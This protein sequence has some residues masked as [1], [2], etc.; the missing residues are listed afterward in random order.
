MKTLLVLQSQQSIA[1]CTDASVVTVRA[2]GVFVL[3]VVFLHSVPGGTRAC[4][5]GS[6]QAL[7]SLSGIPLHPCPDSHRWTASLVCP[8]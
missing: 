3:C 7:A 8:V 6:A 1:L 2:A 4:L 5:S